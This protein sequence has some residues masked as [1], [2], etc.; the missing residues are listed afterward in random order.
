MRAEERLELGP[1]LGDQALP[2]IGPAM[3]EVEGATREVERGAIGPERQPGEHVRGP[4]EDL[5][6]FG[7]AAEG[8]GDHR[9][10][11]LAVGR[12]RRLLAGR[13]LGGPLGMRLGGRGVADR[14]VRLGDPM[15]GAGGHPLLAQGGHEI[16]LRLRPAE[17]GGPITGDDGGL[18]FSKDGGNRWWKGN[19]LPISQFYHVSVD[20]EDP[21]QVYGG[22]Q[23]NSS[24]V[25]QSHYPGGIG[26]QQWENMYGGDGFWMF[27]VANP[28]I[29]A[30]ARYGAPFMSVVFVNRSYSTGTHATA[31]YYPE[32]YSARGSLEGG[33]FDPPIDFAKEAEAAGAYA[34]TVRDPAEVGPAF[35]RGLE[36]IR[37]GT[38]AVIALWL[39]KLLSDE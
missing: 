30:A 31:M 5:G 11:E 37:R 4:G 33:Y 29:W 8:I 19:N 15:L 23:D 36:Q 20:A 34:E 14:Q 32:G 2:L 9:Q 10:V 39:P 24:W 21:Y 7:L 26:N 38:P 17:G 22:L 13:Q 35:R 12:D 25:G 28:A 27:A 18:W 6:G 16:E 1:S 3:A